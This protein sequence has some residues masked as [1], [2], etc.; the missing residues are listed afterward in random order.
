VRPLVE[1]HHGESI[2]A[3]GDESLSLFPSAHAL[4]DEPGSHPSRHDAAKA[5]L[6]VVARGVGELWDDV[7]EPKLTVPR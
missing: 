1:K 5:A 2:E 6:V 4:L 3:R 7:A